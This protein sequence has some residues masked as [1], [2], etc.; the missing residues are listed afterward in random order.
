MKKGLV[1]DLQPR[2]KA[3][4]EPEPHHAQQLANRWIQVDE[5]QGEG[6]LALSCL[7]RSRCLLFF[8]SP[9]EEAGACF[10]RWACPLSPPPPLLPLQ[11]QRLEGLQ[12]VDAH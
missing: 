11:L 8:L 5:V 2:T 6:F 10:R 12:G 1:F 7:L 3:N 9:R 4:S